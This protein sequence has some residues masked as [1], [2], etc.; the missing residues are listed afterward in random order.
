MVEETVV[1]GVNHRLTPSLCMVTFLHAPNGIF[2]LSQ[3]SHTQ[4]IHIKIKIKLLLKAGVPYDDHQ[5]L[6]QM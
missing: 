1:P 6:H 4:K 2:S 3:I 5:N